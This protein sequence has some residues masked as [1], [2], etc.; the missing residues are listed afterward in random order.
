MS[1]KIVLYGQT[2]VG[3]RRE[4]NED[5][6]I[7]LSA[8]WNAPAR[9]LIG[10]IDGVGGYEGGAEAAA[11]AKETIEHYLQNFS[12]GAPLQL[13]KEAAIA[14]NNRIVEQRRTN[15]ALNRMSC[16]MSVAVLDA[17]KEMMYV[18]H[19]GDSRGYVFRNGNML[20]ITR[21]HSAVGMKEDS[22][23]LT[24]AEAMQ[25]PRRNEISKMAG[26]LFLDADD[27]DN[28]FDSIEHSFLPGDIA[29]FCS[30]GLTDLVTQAQMVQLLS[31]PGTLQQKTQQLIDAANELGGK[32]NITVVL[33]SYA[34]PKKP[35]RKKGSKTAIEVP[36]TEAPPSSDEIMTEIN[37]RSSKKKIAVLPVII[38]FVVGFLANWP[39]TGSFFS[40]QETPPAVLPDTTG[41]RPDSLPLTD[42]A[43]LQHL[44]TLIN[45]TDTIYRDSIRR[46]ALQGY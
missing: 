43:H 25:H 18:A 4:E 19:V 38:A 21:D 29:L 24:E 6:F 33:A 13:L 37:T 20:K 26:E 23:Y 8:L 28:Y 5:N 35:G 46:N 16:V 9:A 44:D 27:S 31:A 17:D 11:I 22:G 39:G 36:I 15:E 40:G 3:R 10:A 2:D 30:D 41:I 42:S 34:A 12:F 7:A 32:D 14:A 45:A 1:R